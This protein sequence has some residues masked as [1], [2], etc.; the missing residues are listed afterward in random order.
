MLRA[1][2][3]NDVL[4]ALAAVPIIAVMGNWYGAVGNIG[5]NFY[6]GPRTD[7]LIGLS[8]VLFLA[9][10]GWRYRRSFY[11]SLLMVAAGALSVAVGVIGGLGVID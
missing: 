1:K 4:M 3:L 9:A 11:G 8:G 5:I 2:T 7:T 6:F 10:L